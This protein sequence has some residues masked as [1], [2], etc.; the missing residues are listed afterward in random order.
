MLLEIC[1]EEETM[2][3]RLIVVRWVDGK[4]LVDEDSLHHFGTDVPEGQVYPT[5]TYEVAITRIT[6]IDRKGEK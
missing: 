3:E 2:V 5:G 6:S 4:L 1:F